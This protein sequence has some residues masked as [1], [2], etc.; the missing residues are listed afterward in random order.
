M[1]NY[2]KQHSIP[3]RGW[4]FI[5][6][7]DALEG[8]HNDNSHYEDCHM[9]G[10]EQIRYI[11]ILRHSLVDDD[12]RV[13]CICAEKMTDDF[14]NPRKREKKL[15]NTINRKLNWSKK[16]WKV[17]KKGNLYLKIDNHLITIFP[18]SFTAKYKVRIDETIGKKYFND[19]DEA[20]MAAFFGIEYLKDHGKW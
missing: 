4:I 18:D 9:C 14:Q 1:I 3:H 20:K 2:W 19:I 11:H 13:G 12:I 5:N 6:V 10:K 8:R 16:K 17:S 15:K 7:V